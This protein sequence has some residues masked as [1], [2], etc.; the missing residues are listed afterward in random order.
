MAV[1][2]GKAAL[3][4]LEERFRSDGLRTSPPRSQGMCASALRLP[5]RGLRRLTVCGVL[6]DLEGDGRRLL[7]EMHEQGRCA[8]PAVPRTCARAVCRA[9]R[10]CGAMT[11]L[12]GI[13]G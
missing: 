3:G 11:L 7:E 2:C 13:S 4:R 5:L 12:I 6:G 10:D 8:L 9:P 1:V